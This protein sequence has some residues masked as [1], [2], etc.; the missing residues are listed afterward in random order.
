LTIGQIDRAAARLQ[1][2]LQANAGEISR[3]MDEAEEPK[4]L[5]AWSA[6][7]G[8]DAEQIIRGVLGITEAAAGEL[9]EHVL[10]T[11]RGQVR[12]TAHVE[13]CIEDHS[14]Q[15]SGLSR[16]RLRRHGGPHARFVLELLDGP[17]E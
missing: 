4:P 15:V 7:T 1:A 12:F 13:L 11:D 3:I 10:D 14:G 16:W 17:A 5:A 9:V 8:P 2:E 6:T